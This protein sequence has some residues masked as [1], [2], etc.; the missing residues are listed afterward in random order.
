MTDSTAL[1]NRQWR[2]KSRPEG[3]VSE[4]NFDW[5]EAEIPALEADSVRVRNIY[6]SLDP[7]QRSWMRPTRGYRDPVGIGEVMTCY[8][9]GV[10]E[11]STH[12]NFDTGDIVTGMLGWQEYAIVSGKS[13]RGLI[14]VHP[15]PN[16]PHY[17]FLGALGA[18]GL[19]AYW[20]LLDIGKP[21]EGE[22]VVVSAAAGATGSLVGQ[23]AKLKGCRVVGIAGT[24]EKCQW[25]TETL[26]FDAAINYKTE[27][28]KA[29]LKTHCP[30]GIDVYFD[31]VGGAIL[32]A[33]LS[34]IN[35]KAR[36]VACGMISAYNATEPVPGP[37]NLSNLVTRRAK[38]E[39]FL[40]TDYYRQME[41]AM[42]DLSQWVLS[43]KLQFRVDLVNGL[44]NTLTA[45]NRLFDG[46]NQGKLIVQ[47]AHEPAE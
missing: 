25:L 24:D 47:V 13:T 9:M 40:V 19:T 23:I 10:V 12:P 39:G 11:E 28:V 22:T 18:V 44:E 37:K 27:N 2:L 42:A 45:F 3:L 29:S 1:I 8:G 46:S 4:E 33:A 36:I 32:E 16:M 21:Q 31:N 5:V 26:G 15:I 43:G 34:L 17:I 38:M 41:T 30:D 35:V 6:L 14:K 20:G 7:A